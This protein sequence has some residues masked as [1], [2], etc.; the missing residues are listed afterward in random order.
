MSVKVIE[1]LF[2][3]FLQVFKQAIQGKVKCRPKHTVVRCQ[4]VDYT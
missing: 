3:T 4:M 2:E 1:T